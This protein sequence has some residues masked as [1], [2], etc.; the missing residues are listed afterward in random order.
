MLAYM[1][2]QWFLVLIAGLL[3]ATIL[4]YVYDQ[5]KDN[6]PAKSV[7]GKDVVFSVAQTDV[8]TDEL[9]TNLYNQG[10]LDIIYMLFERGV[11]HAAV[12]TTDVMKTKAEVDVE[13]VKTNFS[14]Y[15]GVD[16][17]ETYLVEAL[18]SM[19]Y[20]KLEDLTDYFIYTYKL[21][22]LTNAH[23]DANMDTL[24]ADFQVTNQPRLVS[25]ALVMMDDPANPTAEETAR[26]E[27]AKA[28]YANGMSF[29][30]VVVNYSDDTSN[31]MIKGSL[32]YMDV[33]T[34]YEENFLNA[35][36]ALTEAGQVSDWIQTSYGW[37]LIRVDAMDLESLKEYQEFYT[38]ILSTDPSLQ[39]NVI[40]S[41]AKELNVD[42]LGNDELKAEILNYMG[43][44]E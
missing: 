14:D 7:G 1:K 42:F 31:N 5:N 18:K 20:T 28:A 21:Q 23:I 26:F 17:Y 34:Q 24:L 35:A 3:F 12:E 41:K 38:A 43:I 19:G 30:D 44:E 40:W 6:L 2:R 13:G 27:E 15:Y 36:L 25:H 8:T 10:G 11:V 39:A 33:T 16:A 37:H 32:G 22:E 4:F 29:E 9:Y